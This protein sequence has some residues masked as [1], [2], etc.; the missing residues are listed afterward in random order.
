M[1]HWLARLFGPA[2]EVV[3]PVRSA[4]GLATSI[5]LASTVTGGLATIRPLTDLLDP[6]RLFE[7]LAFSP[8]FVG[9]AVYTC[10]WQ[11][12][13]A[14]LAWAF[15]DW[16]DRATPLAAAAV[17][18]S[19]GTLAWWPSGRTLFPNDWSLPLF[20]ALGAVCGLL[21]WRIA[22]R[23]AHAEAPVGRAQP[24]LVFSD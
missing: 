17:G 19:A 4:V 18:A 9:F 20:V 23:R 12:L 21:L 5:W 1:Q 10:W 14:M 13:L 2:P 6:S 7:V 15:L 24:P 3:A 16:R 22:Y 8:I 11:L